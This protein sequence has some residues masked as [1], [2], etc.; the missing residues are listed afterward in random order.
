MSTFES[1]A[2]IGTGMMGPGIA[3]ALALGGVRA[4]ILS[5][6]AEGAAKGLETARR[7]IAAARRERNRRSGAGGAGAGAGGRE[8]RVRRGGRARGPGD[9][10][11]A[12][13]HGVQAEAVSAYGFD[14]QAGRGAGFEYVGAEH[15]G[16]R[17]AVRASGARAHD[18]LL[19]SAASDAAGRDCEGGEDVGRSGGGSAGSACRS[20]GR[21]R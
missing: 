6:T 19:E 18:A 12:G 15:H 4:T 11:G 13:E 8:L 5:R 20:A 2:V 10:I 7:Q 17:V 21:R 14:C 1:A 16:G 9:R 3:G